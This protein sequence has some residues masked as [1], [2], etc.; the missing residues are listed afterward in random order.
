MPALPDDSA[1][2]PVMVVAALDAVFAT[3]I[4]RA[5]R[6]VVD[7]PV[8]A[9]DGYVHQH[10]LAGPLTV[11]ELGRRL[12]VTQQ[13]ASARVADMEA[14]GFVRVEPD[15]DDGRRRLVRLTDTARAVVTAARAERHALG[16]EM[17]ALLGPSEWRSFLRAMTRIAD[18]V[19]ATDVV[20]GRRFVPEDER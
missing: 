6:Q 9:S 15:P 12:G 13:R 5:S 10:L 8:R 7:A 4:L 19:G 16:G 17:S 1:I 14:R 11:S 18:G 3:R 20:D 2:D